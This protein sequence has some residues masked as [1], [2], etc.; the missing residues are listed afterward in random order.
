M[1]QCFPTGH[2][3]RVPGN[4]KV[5]E[6]V[7]QFALFDKNSIFL[8]GTAFS[9]IDEMIDGKC[10]ELEWIAFSWYQQETITCVM[11]SGIVND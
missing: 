8:N 6:K 4:Y 7:I 2:E 1:L 9:C 3:L 11:V 10:W 5:L